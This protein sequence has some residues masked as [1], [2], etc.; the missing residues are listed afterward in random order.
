[1]PELLFRGFQHL[2]SFYGSTSRGRRFGMSAPGHSGAA[3][4]DSLGARRAQTTP[5]RLADWCADG[6]AHGLCGPSIC[7]APQPRCGTHS[8]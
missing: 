6:H 7:N 1:M 2:L 4:P 8:G 5:S 3:R